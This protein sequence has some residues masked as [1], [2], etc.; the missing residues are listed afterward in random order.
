MAVRVFSRN[1]LLK[2]QAENTHL[3]HQLHP[4]ELEDE[5]ELDVSREGAEEDEE[6]DEMAGVWDTWDGQNT[7]PQTLSSASQVED[8]PE[9]PAFKQTVL[10]AKPFFRWSS[11]ERLLVL[12]VFR[13]T[14]TS[15]RLRGSARATM[16]RSP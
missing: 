9:S 15:L 7:P 3:R 5:D 11:G 10:K 12:R 14:R 6:E 2:V 16:C 13:W 8:A 1:A 4:D